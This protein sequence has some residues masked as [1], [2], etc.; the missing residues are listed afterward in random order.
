MRRT[1]NRSK[2]NRFAALCAILLLPL[3]FAFPQHAMATESTYVTID[4]VCVDSSLGVTTSDQ[5][6]QRLLEGYIQVE[7]VDGQL[8]S[9]EP[10]SEEDQIA[11]MN[12]TRTPCRNT[13]V[14]LTFRDGSNRGFYGTGYRAGA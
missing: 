3:S 6:T 2:R 10:L 12:S 4:G 11:V 9:V 5:L 1:L 7:Y 14:C 8:A 13:D